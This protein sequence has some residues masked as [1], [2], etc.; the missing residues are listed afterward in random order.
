MSRERTE[1]V[2]VFRPLSEIRAELM[3]GSRAAYAGIAA[4]NWSSLKHIL[5]SPAHYQWALD[6]ED[7]DTAARRLGRNFHVATLEPERFAGVAIWAEGVRRGKAWDAFVEKAGDREILTVDE[8][9]QCL[10]MA[11]A[12]RH[13]PAGRYIL[14]AALVE[15]P[16][17]WEVDGVRCKGIPDAVSIDGVLLDLKSTGDASPEAFGRD[18]LRM[19]YLAQLAFYVDGYKAAHGVELSATLVAVETSAPHGVGVYRVTDLQLDFGRSVYRGALATLK[20]CRESGKWPGLCER[21][22]ELVLPRWSG[23]AANG[24]A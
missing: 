7:D 23:L 17:T 8:H 6:A 3:R 13:S 15:T 22:T 10:A 24:E 11:E 12:V 19:G 2:D 20:A 16:L 4:V 21:E 18:V 5:R 1:V 9:A 14:D